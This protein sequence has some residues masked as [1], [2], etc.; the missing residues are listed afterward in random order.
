MTFDKTKAMRNAEKYLSQGKIRAAIGEYEQVVKHDARDF[1]TMNMLG[2][3]YVKSSEAKAAI[4]CYTAVAD[5]YGKQGFAQKAIA[6]YNKISKIEPHSIET[7]IKLADLYKLKGSLNDARSH[8]TRIADHFKKQG[9]I[10]EALAMW[11]EIHTSDPFDTKVYLSLADSYLA[12]GQSEEALEAYIE[13]GTRLANAGEHEDAVTAFLKALELKNDDAKVLAAFVKS[14]FALGAAR[15]AAERVEAT[16]ADFPHNREL[17]FLLI[18]CLIEANDIPEAEKAVIKLVEVEP[19]NYPKL[20]ELAHLYLAAD[21]MDSA[22]R[23]LSMSSEHMLVGGQ[24]DDFHLLVRQILGKNP[25]QLDAL[26]LLARYCSW[27]RD[28]EALRD[29]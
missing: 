26:R 17:R 2:D 8:Y 13:A 25:D 5:H 14:K 10:I 3:L 7:S 9:Q 6:V 27:Q 1:G 29:L 28:E 16:L 20:L 22:T 11:K 19:A 24:A 23:I 21:D 12:E 4:K 18:D 15:D